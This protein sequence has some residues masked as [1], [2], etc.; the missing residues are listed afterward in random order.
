MLTTPN[1]FLV[2]LSQ[3]LNE[4]TTDTSSQRIGYFNRAMRRIK[5]V[6]KWSWN[7]KPHTLT[8]VADTQEY[9][10]TDEISDYT[11]SW[12][13]YEIYI[14]G[15]KADPINYNLKNIA[16]GTHWYL[17]PDTKTIGFTNA[18]DGTEEIIIWYYP[19][20]TKATASNST[21][22]PE[23]PESILG[24]A[25]LLMKSF[26]HGGKRQRN[27]ERNALLDYKEEIDEAVLQDASNKAKDL[28][29]T[30]PTPLTYM[31]V[32]RTYRY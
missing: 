8:V 4:K 2:E 7:K 14:N 18:L 22:S 30:I 27:D 32:K 11:P 16:Q 26:V 17:K 29:Q 15:D 28:P 21:L 1:D 24:P 5:S 10:L 31:R 12:G 13:V 19:Q 20:H 25:C 3:M 9:D 23:L 6:R